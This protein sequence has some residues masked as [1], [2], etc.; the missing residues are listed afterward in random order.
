MTFI[1]SLQTRR[2]FERFYF[3][4]FHL[5]TLLKPLG[6]VAL[7]YSELY[8]PS[9]ENWI[10]TANMHHSRNDHQASLLPNGMVLVTGGATGRGFFPVN[11]TE[12]YDPS[13]S[14]WI[15]G[16]NMDVKR[17]WH[18]ASVLTNGNV[19][20]TGG[21]YNDNVDL[22][23]TTELYNSS[24]AAWT[25]ITNWSSVESSHQTFI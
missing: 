6:D 20:V 22:T 16:E 18:T 3:E 7:H 1:H 25:F 5:M 11:L 24:T 4:S 10:K 9:S 21:I 23:N 8:D 17:L 19:L 15:A 2:F 13:N 12:L 14:T